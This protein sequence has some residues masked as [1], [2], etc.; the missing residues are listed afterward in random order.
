MQELSNNRK[1]RNATPL[2]YDGIAFKSKLEVMIYKTLKEGGFPVQYEPEKISI[3][4]GFKPTVPFYDKDNV[5]RLLKLHMT[6]L[7]NITYTPDFMFMYNGYQVIV[8][9]KGFINETFPIKLKLFRAWL[10]DHPK[11]IYFEIHSKK[12]LLQAID[13]IK[14][15]KQENNE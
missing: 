6:K 7:L 12:Q 8:E 13:I 5:S 14:N 4:E 3:W 9:G 1:I 11:S 15:L 10:E 2:E